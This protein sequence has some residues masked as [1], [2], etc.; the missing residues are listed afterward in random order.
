MQDKGIKML[1]GD[2]KFEKMDACDKKAT[3]ASGRVFL[4]EY[5]RDRVRRRRQRGR[6]QESPQVIGAVP[7]RHR[8]S[9]ARASWS[10]SMAETLGVALLP[11]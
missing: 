8:P 9:S 1:D 3:L 4:G 7:K 10:W 5:H 11:F 2:T 6:A